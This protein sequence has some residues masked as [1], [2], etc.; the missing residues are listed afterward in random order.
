MKNFIK[1]R[2]R[3]NLRI[4]SEYNKVLSDSNK[5]QIK[6]IPYNEIELS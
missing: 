1:K 4:P 3:E 2:L 6:N 5:Q